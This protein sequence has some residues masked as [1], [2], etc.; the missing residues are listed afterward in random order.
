MEQE[1]KIMIRAVGK[2]FPVAA[3]SGM[4]QRQRD[5]LGACVPEAGKQ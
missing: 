1:N 2:G 3:G 4:N 5:H